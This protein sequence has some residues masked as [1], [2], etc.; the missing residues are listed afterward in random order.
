ME[1]IHYG[2]QEILRDINSK[3]LYDEHGGEWAQ[4]DFAVMIDAYRTAY[5]RGDRGRVGPEGSKTWEVK[6]LSF[7]RHA[8]AINGKKYELETFLNVIRT[9]GYTTQ[10]LEWDIKRADPSKLQL[11]RLPVPGEVTWDSEGGT[12]GAASSLQPGRLA[13][14]LH[15]RYIA[16]LDRQGPDAYTAANFQRMLEAY[17]RVYYRDGRGRNKL[18]PV[19]QRNFAEEYGLSPKS[20]S[21]LVG[22]LRETLGRVEKASGQKYELWDIVED[23]EPLASRLYRITRRQDA[24]VEPDQLQKLIRAFRE[25]ERINDDQEPASKEKWLQDAGFVQTEIAEGIW[26]GFSGV[27]RSVGHDV[28]DLVKQIVV[29]S[30][31]ESAAF[32]WQSAKDAAEPDSDSSVAIVEQTPVGAAPERTEE[33]AKIATSDAQPATHAQTTT[34]VPPVVSDRPKPVSP[35]D[36]QSMTPDDN[37]LNYAVIA[38]LAEEYNMTRRT[39]E[40][41][42]NLAVR[43]NEQERS[44]KVSLLDLMTAVMQAVALRQGIGLDRPTREGH[45]LDNMAEL[46]DAWRALDSHPDLADSA[47]EIK[48]EAVHALEDILEVLTGS[49]REANPD[50][51]RVSALS[52]PDHPASVRL[53]LRNALRLRQIFYNH[54][55]PGGLMAD[56]LK[57]EH[58]ESLKRQWSSE[59]TV[60]A[61]QAIVEVTLSPHERNDIRNPQHYRLIKIEGYI[62]QGGDPNINIKTLL[63]PRPSQGG[64]ENRRRSELRASSVSVDDYVRKS[65]GVKTAQSVAD[66]AAIAFWVL[67]MR[68][69]RD[70]PLVLS[71]IPAAYAAETQDLSEPERDRALVLLERIR[72]NREAIALFVHIRDARNA[73]ALAHVLESAKLLI[74]LN[75]QRA[76][77]VVLVVDSPG[78]VD[79]VQ[80]QIM[81]FLN[82][83]YPREARN[84]SELRSHLS[85]FAA[86][87]PLMSRLIPRGARSVWVDW[88]GAGEDPGHVPERASERQVHANRLPDGSFIPSTEQQRGLAAALLQSLELLLDPNQSGLQQVRPGLYGQSSRTSLFSFARIFSALQQISASA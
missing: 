67:P 31:P 41:L 12:V 36:R 39:A 57:G 33:A 27:L 23:I 18:H 79:A 17:R 83:Q 62:E 4:A 87:S 30:S 72:S 32:E 29:P 20:A 75:R 70:I 37:D 44:F 56:Y 9:A 5:I 51:V 35:V 63:R 58:L 80:V 6:P 59:R 52:N 22:V 54:F 15:R 82:L 78:D 50:I 45:V 11:L 38:K 53:A 77:R 1:G 46:R 10:F 71:W 16:S 34:P 7:A 84:R 19:P 21:R 76:H 68:L 55:I 81:D 64:R 66:V 69:V 43:T 2:M 65:M 26:Q 86:G 28:S 24:S 47:E 74:E 14:Q 3:I 85:V 60:S 49:Y 25:G 42:V 73:A 8:R 40:N 13:R 48:G 61:L 88:Y